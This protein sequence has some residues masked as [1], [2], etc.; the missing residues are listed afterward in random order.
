MVFLT[1]GMLFTWLGYCHPTDLS[2]GVNSLKR[3]SL[4]SESGIGQLIFHSNHVIYLTVV[5]TVSAFSFI[6][7]SHVE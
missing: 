5:I 1:S 4:T 3:L 2:L 6:Y 7:L